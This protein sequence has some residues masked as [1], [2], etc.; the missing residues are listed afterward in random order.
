MTNPRRHVWLV[1]AAIVVA[2]GSIGTFLAANVITRNATQASRQQ[3]AISSQEIASSLKLAIQ[4]EQDLV[5]SAGAFYEGN[6]NVSQTQ[7]L[8]WISTTRAFARYPELS[9][10]AMVRI[11]TPSQLPA[12]EKRSR[13][14]PAGV[15][16]AG[17]TFQI[18][19]AGSRPLYCFATVSASSTGSST[20]P[21]GYDFCDT[22]LGPSLLIARDN[23]RGEYLPYGTGKGELLVLGSPI[24]RNGVTPS[25]VQ[26]RRANFLGWSGTSVVPSVLIDSALLNHPNTSVAFTYV[27]GSDTFTAGRAQSVGQSLTVYLHN[28]W[29]V[30]THGAL[31]GGGLFTN[32]NSLILLLS[33]VG[34]SVV[35]GMLIFA[36]GTGRSR[37]ILMVK[38]RTI[39]LQH[40][41]LHDSLTGL[42]NRALIL[43]RIEQMLARARRDKSAVAVLF[44]DLDNF[45]DVN[46]TLGHAAGDQLL[47]KVGER[48][49][50]VL[51]QVD[52]VGRLGGDEFV[53][54]AEGPALAPGAEAV[55]QRVLDVLSTPFDITASDVPLTVSASIGI[56]EGVREKPEDLLRDADIALYQAKGLGRRRA[57]AF[58]PA[59][60]KVVDERHSLL[61]DLSVGLDTHQFF[62]LYQPTI[63]L[64]TG[65]FNGVE[66]LLRWRH[67]VRGILMPDDFVP[68][69]EASGL[70]LAVGLWSLQEACRQG[71]AWRAQGHHFPVS[72]NVSARQL[73]ADR[74]I[75][76][77]RDALRTSGFDPASLI[78]EIS[79]ASL[80][81]EVDVT[82]ARLG[83]LKSLGVH[84]AIDD[85]GTW[86]SSLAYLRRFPIDML[87]IDRS[88]VSGIADT[89]EAAALVR[90]LVQL[91]R[92]L[93]LETVAGGVESREQRRL[94]IS[95][96]VDAGQGFLFARPLDAEGVNQ[97]LKDW[98]G[99]T[100][101]TL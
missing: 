86:Y 34:G 73:E 49:S 63:N 35:L 39:E 90:T 53:V 72:V 19:P 51:R 87:K 85:F 7:F 97:L 68:A 46:D 83:A 29:R 79:E 43:D 25:T 70:M 71:A 96:N 55:A 45:K 16:G 101:A 22:A 52:T 64:A 37:A 92:A 74:I 17:G 38:E 32:G 57:V 10:I 56:A 15:L 26:A 36:L 67:P 80:M 81:R 6:A 58:L 62:L 23:G 18:I 8:R 33:G 12:F 54:L 1:V 28:G 44:L 100:A 30:T 20:T 94:L 41:A 21:A 50:S 89:K 14:H 11:V 24:Y 66:A 3:F 78:L 82:I 75:A 99:E 5:V 60:Q 76:D 47:V 59:M 84:L 91:G 88:F 31:S 48:L 93:G 42:P 9:G 27:D 2:L 61:L 69:L 4:H 77:V 98:E 95:E 13:A 65:A 40:Q